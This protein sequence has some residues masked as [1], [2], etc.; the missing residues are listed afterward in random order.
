MLMQNMILKNSLG[1]LGKFINYELISI[2]EIIEE[3][4]S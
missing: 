3:I 1:I 4:Y 2:M